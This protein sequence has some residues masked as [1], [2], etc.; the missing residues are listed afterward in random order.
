MTS[1]A[2]VQL[3]REYVEAQNIEGVTTDALARCVA[4]KPADALAFMA[5]QLLAEAARRSSANT[6]RAEALKVARS[7]VGL[8]LVS[9]NVV[10]EAEATRVGAE[11]ASDRARDAG[12]ETLA[13][14]TAAAA[15][16]AAAAAGAAAMADAASRTCA[17]QAAAA[18]SD[19]A[20]SG[21]REAVARATAAAKAIEKASTMVSRAKALGSSEAASGGGEHVRKLTNSEEFTRLG[22]TMLLHHA[23]REREREEANGLEAHS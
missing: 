11:L 19:P 7:W 21:S 16:A 4:E 3:A 1:D 15:A 5:D 6:Q 13:H 17:Q 2:S 8:G 20:A 10:A 12:Q 22:A 14:A 18:S 9:S 23:D